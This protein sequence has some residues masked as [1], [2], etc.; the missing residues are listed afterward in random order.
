MKVALLFC[1]TLVLMTASIALATGDWATA[2]PGLNHY[3]D[4]LPGKSLPQLL[5]ENGEGA[6][7]HPTLTAE[8]AV[9]RFE[10]ISAELG[11]KSQ[12]ASL[13]DCEAFLEDARWSPNLPVGWINL[14]LD[15]SDCLADAATQPT[16]AA[17][18]CRWRIGL[19]PL[20]SDDISDL[21]PKIK[22]RLAATTNRTA[23]QL[24]YLLGALEFQIYDGPKGESSFADVVR[25]F[26]DHPRAETAAFMLGRAR[27]EASRRDSED[28][29]KAKP[30]RDQAEV[31]F[32]SYLTT[33]PDGRYVGDVM[34]WLGA[35]EVKRDNLPGALEWYLKQMEVKNHPENRRSASRMVER[36]MARLLAMPDEAPLR[37]IA[38]HPAVAMGTVYWL[39]H[40][41]EADMHNGFYDKPEAVKKWRA[42]WLPRLAAA[43]REESD[44][45][46]DESVHPWFIAILA[47]A[48]SNAGNQEEAL[49]LLAE[50]G[51]ALGSSDDLGFVRCLILQRQAK[52][53]AAVVAAW[54]EFILLSHP[55]SSLADGARMR[56]ASALQTAGRSDEAVIA[57]AALQAKQAG[58][59]GDE[60]S[61]AGYY[62][63]DI[64]PYS[65]EGLPAA[66]SAL[67]PDVSLAEPSQVLQHLD[68]LLAFGPLPELLRLRDHQGDF[69]PENWEWIR[70]TLLGRILS[71]GNAADAAAFL[72]EGRDRAAA[73]KIARLSK[74]AREENTA[75]AWLA[76]GEGWAGA[77]GRVTFPALLLRRSEIYQEEETDAPE[78]LRQEN[79][80]VLG[81]AEGPETM[82]KLL[83]MDE[84]MNALRAWEQ[85]ARLA[86]PGTTEMASA[87]ENILEA[88]PRVA[89]AT[90]WAR[91]TAIHEQWSQ[92]A[93]EVY[94]T[95]Q[96]KCP[97]TAQAR[98]AARPSFQLMAENPAPEPEPVPVPEPGLEAF[99]QVAPPWVDPAYDL[100]IP[101]LRHREFV[102]ED[103]ADFAGA[104][105]PAAEGLQ[106][107]SD[108][109]QKLYQI[110]PKDSPKNLRT[111]LL[112]L[113]EQSRRSYR[114]WQEG[115][116]HSAI[117]DLADLVEK[118]APAP[119]VFARYFALRL[120]VINVAAFHIYLELR[121]VQ[122]ELTTGPEA[123][124]WVFDE[125]TRAA[126]NPTMAPVADRLECLRLLVLSN[127]L[128][129]LPVVGSQ[130]QPLTEEE[131]GGET[132]IETRDYAA[133]EQ[134]AD[135]WLA[136]YPKSAK[137]EQAW[138]L[139]LRAAYRAR[140][141][142]LRSVPSG[143][144]AGA[145]SIGT[146]YIR[147]PQPNLLPWDA[148]AV[149]AKIAAYEKE[150][151]K[152]RYA[153]EV[154]DLRSAL[155]VSR[156]DWPEA[157]KLCIA[158]LEDP[159]HPDLHSDA[160]LRLTNL[161]TR[162]ADPSLRQ[163]VLAAIQASPK[164]K[165]Y[166]GRYLDATEQSNELYPLTFITVWLREQIGG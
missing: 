71:E 125:L 164:A 97:G 88:M 7:N 100:G 105:E 108:L 27:F 73:E 16:E 162:L 4:R 109:L 142:L 38:K 111:S 143:F 50:A 96:E 163:E 15:L 130:G 159:A 140:R 74:A 5:I 41:P 31:A 1:S 138:L 21:Q 136:A 42:W 80:L 76:L 79:A 131:Q 63:S 61:G 66:A 53:P 95:L 23:A 62:N 147:T 70:G 64:Y 148:K 114:I 65:Y 17:D 77:R 145:T 33:Y 43:V 123:D 158:I 8:T 160:G 32:Q 98:R 72:P 137:R 132:T 122:G 52:D 134:A 139:N 49:K 40:A 87:L 93:D 144:P 12:K 149:E 153:A 35:V 99:T 55:R 26:P 121:P 3:V 78:K 11:T 22:A 10:K 110:D 6:D 20:S 34:G 39:L 161:F 92:T 13:A 151:P 60:T 102:S 118:S 57:I 91:R 24:L 116:V 58:Q 165:T 47:H 28:T 90:P 89:A 157:L 36:V 83:D 2:P 75:S 126:K 18:Y 146:Y 113:R 30:L 156:G 133:V 166:L 152:P 46:Q 37:Q 59:Q 86:P 127:R 104:N 44:A 120:A 154:R 124:Q 117:E 14:G 141:P 155:A 107:F 25:R 106:S 135:K 69:S 68:A 128:I 129:S 119:E 112:N 48:A 82:K 19:G 103:I 84:L 51:K 81:L 56:L 29:E 94:A 115:C 45:W 67:S 54:Q 9:E 150:F 101:Y 85:A